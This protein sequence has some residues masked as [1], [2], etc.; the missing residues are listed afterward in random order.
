MPVG[1]NKI[2]VFLIFLIA[3]GLAIFILNRWII[4]DLGMLSY[5]RVWQLY[6]SYFDVGFARRALIGTILST[7]QVNRILDNEY[8]FAFA[9]QSVL[10][11]FLA[12]SLAVFC[13]SR[14]INDRVFLLGVAL[15]PALILHSGYGTGSLDIFVLLLAALNILYT[16]STLLFSFIIAM[17]VMTHELFLFT[18]PTQYLAW[19]IRNADSNKLV[20]RLNHFVPLLATTLSVVAVQFF[21]F[22][23]LS[24]ADYELIMQGRLPNATGQHG[25]WS[26]Y[27]ELS[28]TADEN[29]GHSLQTLFLEVREGFFYLFV[30]LLYVAILCM[31]I[32]GLT[33]DWKK[34][35]LCIVV[36]LLPLLVAFLATDYYRWISMSSN[37]ALLLTLVLVARRGDARSNWNIALLAFCLF[38]PFGSAAID[39]PFPLHQFALERLLN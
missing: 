17:G 33:S 19:K 26:G 28:S 20:G 37:M 36:S 14:A 12:M 24:R 32:I 29:V 34:G 6:V 9:M 13:A 18:I 10:I 25:L 27:F 3:A 4:T 16:R 7:T 1:A 15:S 39:R 8:E 38:A 23:D 31:R 2:N 21:G 30:P 22:I 5:G 11:I 35:F